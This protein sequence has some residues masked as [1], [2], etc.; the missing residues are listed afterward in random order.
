MSAPRTSAVVPARSSL[1]PVS[2]P[3]EA[4][5]SALG[6]PVRSA[7]ATKLVGGLS[8]EL[9]TLHIVLE[10]GPLPGAG[11]LADLLASLPPS[12]LPSIH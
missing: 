5:S 9:S 12:P 6:V 3:F 1:L 10:D 7:T 8:G 2:P 11:P 4:L